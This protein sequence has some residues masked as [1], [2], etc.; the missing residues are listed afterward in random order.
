MKVMITAENAELA[1][2]NNAQENC[3]RRDAGVMALSSPIRV[4]TSPAAAQRTRAHLPANVTLVARSPSPAGR[5]DAGEPSCED[6]EASPIT[7]E[8]HPDAPEFNA[9]ES[10]A[11]AHLYRDD[12]YR[13]KFRRTRLDAA[14]S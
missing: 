2:S 13:G 1:Q 9:A 12:M 4:V 5:R 6:Q 7:T 3:P 8:Q 11:I 14:T 10:G